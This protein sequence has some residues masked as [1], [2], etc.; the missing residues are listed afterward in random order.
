MAGDVSPVAMF[1]WEVLKSTT[2]FFELE[3]PPP[4]FQKFIVFPLEITEKI[5][6]L[7]VWR[8][9]GGGHPG[10]MAGGNYRVKI[11]VQMGICLC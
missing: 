11:E 1:F 8:G 6:N 4:L 3:W 10:K 2:K 9:R 5:C 7:P